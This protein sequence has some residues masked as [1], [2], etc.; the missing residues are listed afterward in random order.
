M[1]QLLSYTI[2]SSVYLAILYIMYKWFIA[3]K[4]NPG[5]NRHVILAI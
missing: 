2:N 1:G 3:D 4:N 5:F